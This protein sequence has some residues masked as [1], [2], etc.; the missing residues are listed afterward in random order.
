LEVWR[1]V[2]QTAELARLRLAEED[3]VLIWVVV[4]VVVGKEVIDCAFVGS[5]Q[6]DQLHKSRERSHH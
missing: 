5:D 4:V 1:V 3:G 2:P 6:R